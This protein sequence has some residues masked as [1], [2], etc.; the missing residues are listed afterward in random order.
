MGGKRKACAEFELDRE[1]IILKLLGC[2]M[3]TLIVTNSL[4]VLRSLQD[5]T[6]AVV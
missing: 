4:L 6:F 2:D 5:G 1:A 3:R